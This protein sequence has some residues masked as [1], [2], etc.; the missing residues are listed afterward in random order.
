M[1][2]EQEDVERDPDADPLPADLTE[3]EPVAA[4]KAL[5]PAGHVKRAESIFLSLIALRPP[6]G[7]ELLVVDAAPVPADYRAHRAT[8]VAS[9]VSLSAAHGRLAERRQEDGNRA[10]SEIPVKAG[11][12]SHS[13]RRRD[14]RPASGLETSQ[15][16]A[17]QD[18]TI[19]SKEE[20][21]E[22][23]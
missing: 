23:T 3:I 8:R 17:A 22:P 11:L 7:R 1:R 20:Y 15:V 12:G 14:L 4:A 6:T 19:R 10:I 5:R 21:H 16:G 13:V 2:G 18:T 9:D